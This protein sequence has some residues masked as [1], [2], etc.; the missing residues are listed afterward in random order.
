MAP[1]FPYFF[2]GGMAILWIAASAADLGA[3]K[4]RRATDR[5]WWA[6]AG[7]SFFM[8]AA[9]GFVR[10]KADPG[11]TLLL[12]ICLGVVAAIPM[13]LWQ[14]R[15][16]KRSIQGSHILIPKSDGIHGIHLLGHFIFTLSVYWFFYFF[17]LSDWVPFTLLLLSVAFWVLQV[18]TLLWVMSLERGL[19]QHLME[20]HDL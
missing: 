4:E 17:R 12:P 7:A 20:I 11:T 18:A 8:T 19:S 16:M 13:L 14:I 9:L 3:K 2:F 6:V 5:L 10:L 1:L 15:S